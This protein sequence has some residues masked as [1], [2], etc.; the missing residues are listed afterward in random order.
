MTSKTLVINA[1]FINPPPRLQHWASV[2]GE[3]GLWFVVQLQCRVLISAHPSS[4]VLYLRKPGSTVRMHF[5]LRDRSVYISGYGVLDAKRVSSV[6]LNG[7]HLQVTNRNTTH[8]WASTVSTCTHTGR[9]C[10]RICVLTWFYI[11]HCNTGVCISG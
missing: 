2:M 1:V 10:N 11:G 9:I 8:P 5:K 3:I 7:D 4:G 6:I